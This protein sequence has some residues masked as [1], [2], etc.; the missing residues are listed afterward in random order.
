MLNA[1]VI[2]KLINYREI[3][4]MWFY[5]DL[6]KCLIA[7]FYL[8]DILFNTLTQK[9]YSYKLTLN[10]CWTIEENDEVGKL[11]IVTLLMSR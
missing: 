9:G 4:Q 7:T 11:T 3:H 6:I 8:H 10:W 5:Y 1:F 2:Y